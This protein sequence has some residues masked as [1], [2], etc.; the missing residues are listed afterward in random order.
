MDREPGEAKGL[1]GVNVQGAEGGQGSG[2]LLISLLPQT[3]PSA[4]S[5]T[6]RMVPPGSFA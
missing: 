4:R 3:G 5:R 1:Y 6:R 2:R